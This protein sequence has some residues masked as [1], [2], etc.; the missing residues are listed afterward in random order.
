MCWVDQ[1]GHLQVVASSDQW[2]FLRKSVEAE[3]VV[4]EAEVEVVLVL[5]EAVG[6]GA[7]GQVV[8]TLFGLVEL[9]THLTVIGITT[10]IV[11]AVKSKK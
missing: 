3:V 11:T 1:L 9:V 4:A 5:P 10:M 6:A 7:V 2:M 8:S